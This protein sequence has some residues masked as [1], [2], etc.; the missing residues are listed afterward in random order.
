MCLVSHA[1]LHE[2]SR[3]LSLRRWCAMHVCNLGLFLIANAEA[4]LFLAGLSLR[5][6]ETDSWEQALRNLYKDFRSWCQRNRVGC[7]Q[8]PWTL[9]SF[10]CGK[11]LA[12]PA[13]FPWLN[14]KAFNSRCV[15]GW[16]AET[17]LTN[18]ICSRAN[19]R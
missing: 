15:L 5:R 18:S 16:A 4:I 13:E 2:S 1:A 9:R 7:S 8:R 3:F 12:K 17:Q 19:D 11:I 6:G 14:C 10:H